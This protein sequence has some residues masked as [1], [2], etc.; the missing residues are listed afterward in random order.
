M[1][2]TASRT[3]AQYLRGELNDT[4]KLSMTADQYYTKMK[5]FASELLALRKP[6]ENDE[7][8]GYLLHG[9]DKVEY[10]SLITSVN[11]NPGTTLE[12]F[13]EHLCSYDMH[14]GVEENDT[15]ISSANLS[16]R[17]ADRDQR[18]HGRA[19]PPRGRS[20]DSRGSYHGGGSG[21]SSD[22]RDNYHDHRNT[23]RD[24]NWRSDE[25]CDVDRHDHRDRRPVN[26]CTDNYRCSDDNG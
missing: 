3:K 8:L 1:F 20:P 4:K 6:T 7:L 24:D 19:S 17:G 25:R 23:R 9:L 13:F 16:H 10:N 15:F 22:Y 2:T 21:G 18:Q 26:R 11:A 14:N 5:G 12:E